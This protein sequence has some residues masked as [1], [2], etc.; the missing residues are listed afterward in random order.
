MGC[1]L[2]GFLLS[3]FGIYFGNRWGRNPRPD[4]VINKNLKGFLEKNNISQTAISSSPLLM[5]LVNEGNK[6]IVEKDVNG[7]Y[8]F[9]GNF[10]N[11]K[12]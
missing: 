2:L 5:M 8:H 10:K 9:S 7:G 4:Q 6:Q 11:A 3:Q 12:D 1:L